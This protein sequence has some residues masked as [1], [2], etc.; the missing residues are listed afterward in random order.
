MQYTYLIVVTYRPNKENNVIS[1]AACVYL[2]EYALVTFL[3]QLMN[4]K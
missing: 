3:V 4:V 1:F 2:P